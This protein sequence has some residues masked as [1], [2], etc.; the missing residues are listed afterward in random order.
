MKPFVR[1]F[2]GLALVSALVAVGCSLPTDES[3][4][5]IE[6]DRLDE[7]LRRV[8]TTTTTTLPPVR[9]RDFA[10]FLLTTLDDNDV[11][12]KVRQ[13]PVPVA[14][15]TSLFDLIDPMGGEG[16]AASLNAEE[17]LINQ[18]R[19]YDVIDI[20]IDD[21]RGGDVGVAT[22]FLET[23]GEEPPGDEVLRDVAAQL[24]WTLTGEPDIGQVL[25]SID[26]EL[27][28]L[29]TT[30]DDENLTS[31]PVD[32]D[33]YA[34]YNPELVDDPPDDTTTTTTSTTVPPDE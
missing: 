26:G 32:T 4:Q 12:R 15:T 17:G 34:D 2:A 13:V 30:N 27:Q 3:A 25:I 21:G 18:V 6:Q 22:V 33:D 9:T 20:S 8:T 7:S 16:F 24:V 28:E 11:T 29:P 5:V 31:E 19:E 1:R 23:I 14:L 10:Y